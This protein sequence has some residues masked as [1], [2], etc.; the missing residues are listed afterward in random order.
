M[1]SRFFFLHW[2]FVG[3][4]NP[5][6]ELGWAERRKHLLCPPSPLLLLRRRRGEGRGL[7][8]TPHTLSH[9]QMQTHATI[10]APIFAYIIRAVQ[11]DEAPMHTCMLRGAC[12]QTSLCAAWHPQEPSA[13]IASHFYAHWR[14]RRTFSQGGIQEWSFP[15]GCEVGDGW[16]H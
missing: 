13:E 10:C 14:C 5:L 3:G 15:W 1:T 11:T 16:H 9:P 12:L 8:H 6:A 7:W 2:L 4:I